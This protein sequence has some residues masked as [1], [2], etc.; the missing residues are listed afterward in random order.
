VGA[1]FAASFLSTKLYRE[2]VQHLCK[3]YNLTQGHEYASNVF[4][5]GWAQ[6]T[7]QRI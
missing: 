3:L 1:L 5:L 2:I 6:G 4:W 7:Q